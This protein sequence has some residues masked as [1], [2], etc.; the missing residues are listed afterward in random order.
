[1]KPLTFIKGWLAVCLCIGLAQVLAFG[2]EPT[3]DA[4]SD[5]CKDGLGRE[6]P[7][8][9]AHKPMEMG[10]RGGVQGLGIT[11]SFALD[12]GNNFHSISAFLDYQDVALRHRSKPGVF[13]RYDYHF[14]LLNCNRWL[15]YAGPG[16]M[17]GYVSD[18]AQPHGI[19]LGLAGNFGAKYLFDKQL[20]LGISFHPVVGFQ[21]NRVDGHIQQNI[22]ESGLWRAVL[23]E[24]SIGYRWGNQPVT[25]EPETDFRPAGQARRRRWTLGAECS[26]K[27]AHYN[28]LLTMYLSDDAS[29][30]YSEE[31]GFAWRHQASIFLSAA[32]HFTDYYQLRLL[33]GYAGIR[34]DV[35]L[36]ELLLRNQWNFKPLNPQGDRFFAGVDVG[37]GLKASDLS[38]P[39][40]LMNLSFGYS[41]ALSADSNIEFFIRSGNCYG[42]PTMYEYDDGL[43]VPP[44]RAYKSRFFV[45]SIEF[46][47]ALDL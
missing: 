38:R 16:A 19:V 18:R 4:A 34:P 21:F 6:T 45:S 26:Y 11:Y 22:Y 43:P 8:R 30:Y 28:Y 35:H 36:H 12:K 41:L 20:S 32:W 31:D 13:L 25:A 42:S 23:P 47:I 44:E 3:G 46:G 2:G 29:R 24:I 33:M 17:A 7:G 15:L 40:A 37:C 9:R 5:V 1:M 10:V 14:S 27:P 39:Y